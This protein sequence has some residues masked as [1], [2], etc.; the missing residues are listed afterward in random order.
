MEPAVDEHDD[1]ED[2][3]RGGQGGD[4]GD[5]EV[6]D[7]RESEADGHEVAGVRTIREHRHEELRQSVGEEDGVGDDTDADRVHDVV[8]LE[9]G[10]HQGH[11]IADQVEAR[12]ADEDAQE[13]VGPPRLVGRS[14]TLSGKRRCRGRRRKEPEGA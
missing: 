10:R 11:V 9:D 2:P 7:G 8:V 5:E 1:R 6:H 13:D 14:D 3:N 4:E 12:V